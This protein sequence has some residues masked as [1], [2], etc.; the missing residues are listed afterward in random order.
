MAFK[1]SKTPNWYKKLLSKDIDSAIAGLTANDST[2]LIFST[3]SPN[4][5]CC[6]GDSSTDPVNP[7]FIRSTTCWAKNIDTSPISVWNNGGGY[8]APLNAGGYGGA[9]TLISPR[10]I[11]LANHFYIKSGK[12]LIFVAMDNTCYIRTLSNSLQVGSSD[13]RIGLLDSDLPANVSF[14]KI[15]SQTLCNQPTFDN[16]FPTL[17]S[18]LSKKAIIEEGYVGGNSILL[19]GASSD[20]QR[21]NFFETSGGGTSGNPICFVYENKL[22]I[23]GYRYTSIGGPSF[24]APYTNAINAVMTSLGGGYQLSI[25]DLNANSPQNKCLIK[26]NSTGGGKLKIT[27]LQGPNQF[28]ARS[29][30]PIGFD[31]LGVTEANTDFYTASDINSQ[32]CANTFIIKASSSSSYSSSSSSP[33]PSLLVPGSSYLDSYY[34][35]IYNSA[36]ENFGYLSYSNGLWTMQVGNYYFTAVGTRFKIPL[37]YTQGVS[38]VPNLLADQCEPPAPA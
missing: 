36:Q 15:G 38:I 1:I 34:E 9:G 19:F 28:I 24:I 4:G 18:N 29:E 7:V 30:Q 6:A 14:C 5:N 17:S 8:S 26:K 3:M 27:S 31:V 23:I 37:N 16:K 12:K 35:R 11:L 22:I 32:Q 20:S 21:V 2:K 33:G 13:I 10:H 25:F